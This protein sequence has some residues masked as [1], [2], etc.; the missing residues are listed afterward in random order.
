M[1]RR[2]AAALSPLLPTPEQTLLLRAS[3]AK[4]DGAAAWSRMHRRLGADGLA[5][6]LAANRRLVPL[7]Y[8]ADVCA[9]YGGRLPAE[10]R[11]RVTAVALREER[12]SAAFRRGAFEVVGML[13]DRDRDVLVLRGAALAELAYPEPYLRH[14]HDLDLMVRQPSGVSRVR[15]AEWVGS[16]ASIHQT[17]FRHPRAQGDDSPMWARSH[18]F[19]FGDHEA[20]VMAPAD[21]LVHVCGHAFFSETRDALTWVT[22][23]WF[24]LAAWPDLDWDVVEAAADE[25]HLGVA[26]ALQL[27]YLRRE[28]HAPVSA[29]ALDRL[30]RLKAQAVDRDIA[31]ALAWRAARRRAP[32]RAKALLSAGAGAPSLVRWR[33]SEGLAGPR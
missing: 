5:G 3:L 15:D 14:C 9:E 22:D 32:S 12:R 10:L 27:G 11:R 4:S 7:L 17:A 13:V 21:L 19:A 20:R 8:Y 1:N 31:L 29:S 23:A 6:V 26:L 24:T 16:R 28:L 18:A 30:S 2:L 33:L 25:R